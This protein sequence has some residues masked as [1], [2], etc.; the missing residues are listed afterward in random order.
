MRA[1]SMHTWQI[2]FCRPKSVSP[3][4]RHFVYCRIAAANPY[5]E[6]WNAEVRKS[7]IQKNIEF[8]VYFFNEPALYLLGRSEQLRLTRCEAAFS[9]DKTVKGTGKDKA[10]AT[11]VNN[12]FISATKKIAD[13]KKRVKIVKTVKAVGDDTAEDLFD[14]SDEN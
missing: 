6:C 8:F 12:K 13:E 10:L 7:L 3:I 11:F 5:R 4:S 2:G 9:A 14:S 1:T